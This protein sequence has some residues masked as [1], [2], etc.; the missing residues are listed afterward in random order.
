VAKKAKK[1][2]KPHA[3]LGAEKFVLLD[4]KGYEVEKMMRKMQ[5][6]GAPGMSMYNR[7]DLMEEMGKTEKLEPASTNKVSAAGGFGSALSNGFSTVLNWFRGF[8][9]SPKD[10]D[11]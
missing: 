1:L 8:F 10:R 11:L 6:N 3:E 4:S 5:A 9:G 2:P 7:E